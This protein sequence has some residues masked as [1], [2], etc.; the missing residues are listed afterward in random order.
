MLRVNFQITS[1]T[2]IDR[3]RFRTKFN[4]VVQGIGIET[5]KAL[6]TQLVPIFGAPGPVV[7]PIRWTSDKQRKAF[8]ATKAWGRGIPTKR[9]GKTER[10]WKVIYVV[11]SGG[12]EITLLNTEPHAKYIYGDAN[13]MHQQSFHR[14]TGWKSFVEARAALFAKARELARTKF[15][16]SLGS[17]GVLNVEV[18]G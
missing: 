2:F 18:R 17:F 8:F 16:E 4:K 6:E 9:T 15:A 10:S 13:G 11:A 5:A 7:Y 1:G 14:R 12:G 3:G